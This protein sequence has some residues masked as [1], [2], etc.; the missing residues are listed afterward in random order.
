M[1]IITLYSGITWVLIYWMSD[2]RKKSKTIFVFL[3]PFSHSMELWFL[4]F[5]GRTGILRFIGLWT[6]WRPYLLIILSSA[7][8]S[9][10]SGL[11]FSWSI[12]KCW[13]LL[14]MSCHRDL[15]FKIRYFSFWCNHK[16]ILLYL[17][18]FVIMIVL[19]IEKCKKIRSDAK[20]GT[21][22]TIGFTWHRSW[23]AIMTN[24]TLGYQSQ[25]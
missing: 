7:E 14:S 18:P 10:L 25:E 22:W 2:K 17:W 19:P 24:T 6:R 11:A 1:S 3:T 8:D 13:N 21:I 12:L 20:F 15:A 9:N 4:F 23:E 5:L 16:L